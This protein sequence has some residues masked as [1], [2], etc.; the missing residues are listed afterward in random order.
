M[1]TQTQPTR[2]GIR[3]P[4]ELPTEIMFSGGGIDRVKKAIISNISITGIQI[5]SPSFIATGQK[6]QASFKVPG[7]SSITTFCAEVMRIESLQGRMI[8]HFPYALGA[9]FIAPE[10]NQERQIAGFISKKTTYSSWRM[11]ITG[12]LFLLSISHIRHA[13]L[14][15]AFTSSALARLNQY[16]ISELG[17]FSWIFH[18]STSAVVF[19]GLF[20]AALLC[21][22][23]HKTFTRWGF[24]WTIASTLL[25][26]VYVYAQRG[27]L[28]EAAPGKAIWLSECLLTGMGIGLLF[29]IVKLAKNMHKM[30]VFLSAQT[31][32]S[33][34]N[35]P[36]FT[37][38]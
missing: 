37:I 17:I 22:F 13:I 21:A 38:L 28:F 36:T 29:A 31:P 3:L 35:R 19:V 4:C 11:A 24:F 15:S 12:I 10:K 18:Q 33:G 25:S 1:T 14:E 26:A 5:L 9:K 34:P 2:S 23:N 6:V 16:G 30:N 20:S 27:L 7:R 32:L 8:G